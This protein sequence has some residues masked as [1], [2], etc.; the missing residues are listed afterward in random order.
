MEVGGRC[1]L[2]LSVGIIAV[3][4][5]SLGNSFG[6]FTTPFP[7]LPRHLPAETIAIYSPDGKPIRT[8]DFSRYPGLMNIAFDEKHILA[9]YPYHPP[10]PLVYVFTAA[11]RPVGAVEVRGLKKDTPLDLR[12]FI[13]GGGSDILAIDLS[14]GMTFRY[15]MP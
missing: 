14:S 8:I 9:T 15:A 12:A 11:G 4:D 3:R 2:L 1:A 7:L 10:T 5:E 13:T 6:G